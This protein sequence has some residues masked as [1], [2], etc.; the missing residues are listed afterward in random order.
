MLI[1]HECGEFTMIF[2]LCIFI[3]ACF[4]VVYFK[5][6]RQ[7]DKLKRFLR[8]Q[9]YIVIVCCLMFFFIPINTILVGSK[10]TGEFELFQSGILF[11]TRYLGYSNNNFSETFT[12]NECLFH[13]SWIELQVATLNIFYFIG[14]CFI[15]SCITHHHH[16]MPETIYTWLLLIF[17]TTSIVYLLS[18]DV[19]LHDLKKI[20]LEYGH[21]VEWVTHVNRGECSYL[22]RSILL[23][24]YEVTLMKFFSIV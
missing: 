10:V 23:I 22:Y 7:T 15:F 21:G 18:L 14:I 24:G 9:G 12:S 17:L 2:W 20:K 5:L 8:I 19:V 3:I 6:D 1:F 16:K 13:N 4:A 11:K